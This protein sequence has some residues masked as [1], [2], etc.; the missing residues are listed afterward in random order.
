M[1]I[2]MFTP[3]RA[4][5]I[6][7]PVQDLDHALEKEGFTQAERGTIIGISQSSISRR[8]RRG[9]TASKGNSNGR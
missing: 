2:R 6:S 7:G 3:D 9:V 8:K 1:N 4:A 5:L